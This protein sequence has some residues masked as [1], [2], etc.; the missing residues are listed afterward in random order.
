MLCYHE[1]FGSVISRGG[2][3]GEVGALLHTSI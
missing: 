2:R 1:K 3:G